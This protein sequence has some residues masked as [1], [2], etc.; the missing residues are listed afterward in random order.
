MTWLTICQN[1]THKGALWKE[2]EG[3]QKSWKKKMKN[4]KKHNNNNRDST[5]FVKTPNRDK[6]NKKNQ[7][8][9]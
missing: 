9:Q 5:K 3:E 2:I 6:N 8:K 7:Q 1:I 4:N